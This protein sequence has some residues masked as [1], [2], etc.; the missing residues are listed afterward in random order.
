M[1]KKQPDTI[2]VGVTYKSY[3]ALDQNNFPIKT[4]GFRFLLPGS[5]MG[6]QEEADADAAE[7]AA[8]VWEPSPWQSWRFKKV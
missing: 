5:E 3:K 7:A 8:L 6:P 2:E 4:A 1:I